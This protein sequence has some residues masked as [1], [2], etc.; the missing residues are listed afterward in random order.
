MMKLLPP[1]FPITLFSF[2]HTKHSD[3]WALFFPV[4][5]GA[6]SYFSSSRHGIS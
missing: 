4:G 2:G 1:V 3:I 5:R 6:L